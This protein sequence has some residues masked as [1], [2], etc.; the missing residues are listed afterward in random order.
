MIKKINFIFICC[1]I[2]IAVQFLGNTN[3]ANAEDNGKTI[4]NGT[5]VI[6]S[7]IN[8]DYVLDV[9]NAAKFD[10]ANVQIWKNANVSQQRFKVEYLNNGYYKITSEN[11]GKVLDVDNAGKYD[12]A[13]V[14]QFS[15]N[16]T[17][18]QLWQ[19]K[20]VGNGYYTFIS[21]CNGRC[22]DVYGGIA[23]NGRNI[24]TFSSNGTKA[25]KFKLEKYEYATKTVDDGTYVVKSAINNNYVFDVSNASKNDRGNVQIWQNANVTQQRFK[26]EYLNNGYYKIISENSGKALDV[27]NA[28]KYDGANVQ[29]FSYNGTDA[30]LWQIKDVGDGYYTFISKCNGRCLDMYGG[31]AENGRNISTFSSN[32]TKAQKFKLEKCSTNGDNGNTQNKPNKKEISNGIM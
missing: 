17:D 16:G 4:E 7:A 21:K 18:A 28:G 30:Q 2:L 5:Y 27:D 32:G 29:Q 25:Q 14:Q 20:D 10:R 31:I 22:L 13:N 1:F 15:Y 11:S 12:G 23:G 26:I 3:L 9:S 24:S 6:I 19:I 8:N